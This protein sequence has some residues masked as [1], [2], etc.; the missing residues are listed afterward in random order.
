MSDQLEFQLNYLKVAADLRDAILRGELVRG[1]TIMPERQLAVKYQMSVGT[2]RKGIQQLVDEGLLEKEHGRGTFVTGFIPGPGNG[3][4]LKI[5]ALVPTISISYYAAM[6]ET[7]EKMVAANNCQFVLIRNPED[8]DKIEKLSSVLQYTHLDCLLVCHELLPEEY[9]RIGQIAPTLPLYF[10]DGD[11]DG[12]EVGYVKINDFYGAQMA[13]DHL[14]GQGCRRIAHFGYDMGGNGWQR[15]AGYRAA[16]AAHGM[17]PTEI[18][19]DVHFEDGVAAADRCW[20]GTGEKPDGIFCVTDFVAMGAVHRL[21]EA[22]VRVSEDV[23]VVGFSNLT[24][25]A[26]HKPSITSL[27]VDLDGMVRFAVSELINKVGKPG[28]K[29]SQVVFNPWLHVRESSERH[30]KITSASAQKSLFCN[31]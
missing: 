13:V 27:E 6:V 29:F 11:V 14:I 9:R 16:M 10:I 8:G 3:K 2:V 22:G 17:T 19:G 18:F 21:L 4:T 20:S 25:A 5:G 31:R 28:A 7:I 24:E 26:Y 12:I 15:L 1:M 30:R 23:G